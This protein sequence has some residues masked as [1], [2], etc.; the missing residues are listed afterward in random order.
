MKIVCTAGR[1]LDWL[2]V[3]HH[4]ALDHLQPAA[5]QSQW[6]GCVKVVRMREELS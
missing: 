1:V 4:T 3:S 2:G 5:C 6:N